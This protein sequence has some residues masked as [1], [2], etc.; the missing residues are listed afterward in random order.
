MKY[1]TFRAIVIAVAVA[2]TGLGAWQC[3]QALDARDAFDAELRAADEARE[4]RAAEAALAAG[5]APPGLAAPADPADPRVT[6]E[7]ALL[8]LLGTPA[9]DEKLKDAIP[10]P[11]KVNVYREGD[12]W[13]RAKVDL[14]RDDK[15]DEKWHIQGDVVVREIAPADDENY[16]Q[17][18][19]RVGDFWEGDAANQPGLPHP[20]EALAAA[21]DAPSAP[22][23]GALRPVD[24]DLLRLLQTPVQAKI[25]DATEGKPYKVNLYSDGGA[26]FERA[27]VDL[28]RDDKWD[29]K[30]TIAE[31]GAIERQVAPADDEVYTET[32]RLADGTWSKI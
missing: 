25:K 20:K 7:R 27:K 28:D 32:Y 15:W 23:A 3:K 4:R 30:W 16:L 13:A 10:G 18:W 19:R 24:D 22:A 6:V 17:T 2:L 5:E 11:I 26:R 8:G 29:E 1:K 21:T 9:A 12:L 31:G 14:D